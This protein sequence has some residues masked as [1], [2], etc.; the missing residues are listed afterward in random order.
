[1]LFNTA[2]QCLSRDSSWSSLGNGRI[3]SPR[4]DIRFFFFF[5]LRLPSFQCELIDW[6][7]RQKL[8]PSPI[9]DSQENERRADR[10][11]AGV[12]GGILKDAEQETESEIL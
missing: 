3:L 9:Y 6:G 7:Q 10:R 12:V 1:M 2:S 11:L 5:S 4:L 8:L